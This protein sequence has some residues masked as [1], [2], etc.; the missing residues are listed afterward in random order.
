MQYESRFF[1]SIVFVVDID[2]AVATRLSI[3]GG[4]KSRS[5]LAADAG[6]SVYIARYCHC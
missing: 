4:E 5:F 1:S 6:Q 2:I 3:S